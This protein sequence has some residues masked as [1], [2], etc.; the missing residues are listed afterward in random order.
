MKAPFEIDVALTRI[1][2][3]IRPFPK[4]GMFALADEGFGSPF[5]LLVACLISIR[6]KDE[7]MVPVARELFKLARTPAQMAALKAEEI[8][9]IIRQSTFS[10]AKAP[11][12]K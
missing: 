6:T 2:E 3:A 9:A 12:L 7:V 4:A 11:R 5:E 1:H 8:E 10:E